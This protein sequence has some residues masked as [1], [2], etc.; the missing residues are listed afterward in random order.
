MINHHHNDLLIRHFGINKTQ[1][2]L[3]W[4]YYWPSLRK[5]IKSYV[6]GCD[7]CL[8]SKAA[9][10]KPYNNLQSLPIQTHWWKNILIE[11]VTGL[12]LSSDWKCDSYNFILVIVNW[13]TKIMHYKQVKVVINAPGLT[14]VIIDMVI[15]Y[16]DLLSSII[17]DC[18]AIF[19]SIFWS[20][21]CYFFGIK[22]RLSMAFYSQTNGQT[23]Q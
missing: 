1:E 18:G 9:G 4:K 22:W 19:M 20:S 3:G 8:T 5:D 12:P 11:F 14:E 7:I 23:E 13:L 21:L 6:K 15:W 17:N 10:Y 16:Y 2:L